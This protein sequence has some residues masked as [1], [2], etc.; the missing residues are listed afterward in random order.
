MRFV[1]LQKIN[2]TDESEYKIATVDELLALK[3][4]ASFKDIALF[5]D[6]ANSR[7]LERDEVDS[8]EP[9][10]SVV[11]FWRYSVLME[12]VAIKLMAEYA[13]CAATSEAT[14]L[15]YGL[16]ELGKIDSIPDEQR[17][18]ILTRLPFCK[19]QYVPENSNVANDP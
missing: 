13:V 3:P 1:P 17:G 4:V 11:K 5:L 7:V 18:E 2:E 16:I 12:G 19:R 10:T 9:A 6:G 15:A 8:A 14:G